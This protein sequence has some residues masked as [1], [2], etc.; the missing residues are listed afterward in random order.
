M[1]HSTS[2]SEECDLQ[3]ALFD[4]LFETHR[5]ALYA[6]HLGRTADAECA[7]DLLQETFVRAW[8]HIETLRGRS[9]DE[10][11]FWLF[12][13]AR[14][15]A[16]DHQRRTPQPAQPLDEE[17]VLPVDNTN[18]VHT[19][20]AQELAARVQTAIAQLPV[21]Y[22]VVLTLQVMGDLNSTQ[23]GQLLARPSGTVRYQINQAR[24]L[25]AQRL[26]LEGEH[27]LE[28]EAK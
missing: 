24:R 3:V 13:T 7:A 6:F 11:R 21:E 1:K 26:Q 15:L 18:P 2:S 25:L 10:Q 5:R 16:I 12:R 4:T 19:V 28:A 9:C 20:E 17:T 22:R 14:N 27:E 8:R 23:I